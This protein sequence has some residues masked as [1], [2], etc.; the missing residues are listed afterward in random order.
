[1]EDNTIINDGPYVR[2][3]Y[4]DKL[5]NASNLPKYYEEWNGHFF[6]A[7]GTTTFVFGTNKV[8]KK[9]GLYFYVY[10]D[11]TSENP[12]PYIN[13][14][15]NDKEL[16]YLKD[17]ISTGYIDSD[18]NEIVINSRTY[19]MQ[20]P[21]GTVSVISENDYNSNPGYYSDLGYKKDELVRIDATE[22]KKHISIETSDFTVT[23]L[24]SDNDSN[25]YIPSDISSKEI[26]NA[27]TRDENGHVTTGESVTNMN[28]R[29]RWRVFAG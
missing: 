10:I 8:V 15:F 5:P 22:L 19:S 12:D 27:V 9:P 1:M 4:V 2:F 6:I 7:A 29:Y 18:T 28:T 23:D 11:P 21:E 14:S 13:L 16:V 24:D 17:N 20:D 3:R 25:R 26:V